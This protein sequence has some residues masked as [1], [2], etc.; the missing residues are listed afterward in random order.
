MSLSIN[1]YK[2]FHILNSNS[3]TVYPASNHYVAIFAASVVALITLCILFESFVSRPLTDEAG[4]SIPSGPRGLPI[5][6]EF[7]LM[8]CL[9]EFFMV[10]RKCVN[11]GFRII[12]VP[13]LLSRANA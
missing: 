4:N 10:H 2:L 11:T 7:D 12:P 13:D 3:A 1:D 8:F 9:L 6:G 5:V